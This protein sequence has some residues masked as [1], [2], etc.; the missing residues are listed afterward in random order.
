MTPIEDD[1]YCFLCGRDNPI[2]LHV[3]PKRE[4]GR[5]EIRWMPAREYQGFRDVLHGGIISALLDEAMAHAVLSVAPGAATASLSACFRKPVR[6]DREIV[7][8]ARVDERRGRLLR[9]SGVLVQEGEERAAAEAKFVVIS[10]KP[11]A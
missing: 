9:A 11:E 4:S 10:R 7:V 8:R 2:G 3:E 5:C 1:R 6:T